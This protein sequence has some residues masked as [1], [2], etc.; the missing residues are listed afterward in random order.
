MEKIFLLDEHWDS[1][2][3]DVIARMSEEACG[4]VAGIDRTSCAVFPVSNMLHSAVRFRMDPEEQLKVFL[5]MEKHNWQLLAIYHSH[6]HGPQGPSATDIAEAYYPEAVNL[7][8]SN[9]S[10]AWNCFGYS[11]GE[12][13]MA[14][15]EVV[16]LPAK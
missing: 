15:V 8:W 1:M 12:G 3:A 13:K 4:I 11:I 5:E 2:Q 10:G 6:L 14:Q 9:T 16:R 7:I